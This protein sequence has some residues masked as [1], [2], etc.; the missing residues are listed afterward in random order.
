VAQ[1]VGEANKTGSV[2]IT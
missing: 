1:S 2:R